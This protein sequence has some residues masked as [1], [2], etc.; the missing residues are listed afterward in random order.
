MPAVL[1]AANEVAVRAFVEGKIAFGKIPQVIEQAMEVAGPGEL[2][3]NG[4]RS[5]DQ[6]ARASA[7]VIVDSIERSLTR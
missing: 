2:S 4:V 1:S 6:E 3:L 7:Q 5:A